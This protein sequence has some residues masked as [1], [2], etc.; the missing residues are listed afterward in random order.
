MSYRGVVRVAE[1]PG[2]SSCPQAS[3]A[4]LVRMFA[5]HAVRALPTR[6]TI[7]RV[8]GFWGGLARAPTD[9]QQLAVP[10][11]PHYVPQLRPAG[12]P[13][14]SSLSALPHF[15]HLRLR[16]MGSATLPPG[17]R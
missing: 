11:F 16:G 3:A 17:Q 4:S 5:G 15:P 12:N 13:H 6:C 1:A 14:E 7:H 10:H 2:G 9:A 8:W